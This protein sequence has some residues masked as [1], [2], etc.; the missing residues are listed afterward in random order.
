MWGWSR[1][2]AVERLPRKLALK[3]TMVFVTY[4]KQKNKSKLKRKQC[5]F[6]LIALIFITNNTEYALAVKKNSFL[7][8]LKST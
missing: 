8:K 2:Y 7:V 6:D 3:Y 5:K 4:C 1:G